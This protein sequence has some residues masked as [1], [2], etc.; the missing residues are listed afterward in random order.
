V[1][2]TEVPLF[3]VSLRDAEEAF[4]S[5]GDRGDFVDGALSLK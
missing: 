1:S 3:G 5:A 4:G 2:L